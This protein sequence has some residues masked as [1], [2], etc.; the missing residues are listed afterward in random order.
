MV[1]YQRADKHREWVFGLQKWPRT[2]D[3]YLV[4]DLATN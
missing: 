1:M 3:P 2:P 4:M